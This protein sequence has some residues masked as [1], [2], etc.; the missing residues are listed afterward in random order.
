MAPTARRRKVLGLALAG[1]PRGDRAQLVAARRES[2]AAA[3]RTPPPASAVPVGTTR[4]TRPYPSASA[5]PIRCPVRI[6][7][8]ATFGGTVRGSRTSPPVP[9]AS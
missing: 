4:L 5:A 1:G 2:H 9:V 3:P 6:I 8:F 7:S